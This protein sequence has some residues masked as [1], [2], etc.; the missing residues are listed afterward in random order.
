MTK[1]Q[2]TPVSQLPTILPELLL[3]DQESKLSGEV[4]RPHVGSNSH[5]S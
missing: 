3:L 1:Q 5:I 4:P 2:L